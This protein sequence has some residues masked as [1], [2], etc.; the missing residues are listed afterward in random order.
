MT[1]HFGRYKGHEID[2][3]QDLQYLEWALNKVAMNVYVKEAVIAR[4]RTLKL[5]MR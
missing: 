3:I 4:I 1:L 5:I 2:T